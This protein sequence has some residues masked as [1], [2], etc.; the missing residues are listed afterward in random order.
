MILF[1][2][3]LARTYLF[4]YLEYH[5]HNIIE[6]DLYGASQFSQ[7]RSENILLYGGS[8]RYRSHHRYSVLVQQVQKGL[9]DGYQT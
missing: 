4:I 1:S 6:T 2:G 7:G 9:C 3:R 8:R 5:L